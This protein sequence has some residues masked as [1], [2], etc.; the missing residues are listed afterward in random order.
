MGK[1]FPLSERPS[2]YEA[3]IKLIEKS[4]HYKKPH[5]FEIDFA[6]LIDKSNHHNCFITL[7]EN[8]NVVAHIGVREKVFSLNNVDFP[9]CLLGGIAVD[10]AR[11]GEGHFQTLFQDVLAEKRSDTT[12]FLLW[13]DL[14]KLYN[15]FGFHLCGTQFEVSKESISN[16]SFTK[17][18]YKELSESEKKEIQNLYKESFQKNYL[19]P[20]RTDTD[21]NLIEKVTSAD[22]F[23]RK[24]NKI[25]Q[26]YYFIN[27]GQDLPGIIYEYGTTRNFTSLVEEISA[28]GKVWTGKDLIPTESLQYQFF[29]SPGDLRL[30]TQF[31][32]SATQDKFL[33]RNINLMKQEV[34]FDFNEETLS[35][36]LH[37]FLRGVFGPGSFEEI[38]VPSIFISG[39]DSV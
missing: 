26:D 20:Q 33:I 23:I 22:L 3:T 31:I 18:T 14:E 6:P 25:I 4:F 11:R 12:F 36:E 13:S 2:C 39:L 7:D 30:F 17:T 37:E 28:F 27:K 9:V 1:I 16:S 32:Q 21:W 29:M 34:F 19:A 35:L 5:S 38:E 8:E 24:D 15:K 10:E